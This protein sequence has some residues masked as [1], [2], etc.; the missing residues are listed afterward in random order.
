MARREKKRKERTKNKGVSNG[1][2]C[3]LSQDGKERD[4]KEREKKREEN[5]CRLRCS[6]SKIHVVCFG[7]LTA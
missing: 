1:F 4:E 3:K 5:T 6:L 2:K 7:S